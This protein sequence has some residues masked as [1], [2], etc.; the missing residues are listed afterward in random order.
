MTNNLHLLTFHSSKTA[1]LLNGLK[2]QLAKIQNCPLT[3]LAILVIS[4][5]N[6]SLSLTKYLRFPSPAILVFEN[7]AESHPT[8]ISKQPIASPPP[9]FTTLDYCNSLYYNLCNSQ[10][11][12]LQQIQNSFACAVVNAPSSLTPLQF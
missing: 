5:T 6:I 3:L 12:R 4:L 1:F 10:L 7:F 9:L 2:Q 8:L 11:N